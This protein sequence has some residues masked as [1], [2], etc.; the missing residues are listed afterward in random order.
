MIS[1]GTPPTGPEPADQNGHVADDRPQWECPECGNTFVTPRM[2]HSCVVVALDEHFAKQASEASG[3]SVGKPTPMRELFDAY[4][5]FVRHHGG[6]V[7]V[8]PQRSRI[9]LQRRVRFGSVLV[10]RN[11]LDVGLWL[12]RRAEHPLL[13]KVDD[14]GAVGCYHWFRLT[15]PGQLDDAL[16]ELVGE[17]YPM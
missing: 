13:S 9:A 12:K 8:I 10:R 6:P 14:Y 11:W 4:V 7:K 15:D 1:Q 17:A 2:S 16:G 5:D 3:S